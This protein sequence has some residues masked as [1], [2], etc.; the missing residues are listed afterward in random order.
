M[1]VPKLNYNIPKGKDA[2][3]DDEEYIV[4]KLSCINVLISIIKMMTPD[5]DAA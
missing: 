1:A 2:A 3:S 5:D 4:S